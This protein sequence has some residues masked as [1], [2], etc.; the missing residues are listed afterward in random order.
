LILPTGD[1]ASGFGNG[2]VGYQTNL[3]FSKIVS[4][5]VTLHFNAG[6]TLSPDVSGHDLVSYNLGASA[7]YAVTPRF[8]LMLESV[9][10]W[11][12]EVN[13][14][15]AA[16]R[17]ASAVISPGFRY[18]FNHRFDA[19]TVVGIAAPIGLNANTPNYGIFLYASFE[20]FFYRPATKAGRD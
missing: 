3:P 9:V 18:A 20:H 16:K 7:V 12:D 8:N 15:G 1:S 5:R 2:V 13:D 14:A 11:N 19:Q 6:A 4:D 10:N 17:T